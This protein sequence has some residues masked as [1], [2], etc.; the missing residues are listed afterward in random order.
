MSKKSPIRLIDVVNQLPSIK[1][2]A[3]STRTLDNPKIMNVG[4]FKKSDL[5]QFYKFSWV[6]WI[7]PEIDYDAGVDPNGVVQVMPYLL[8]QME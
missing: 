1:R 3:L 6:K 2:I 7:A 4:L 5:Y 8:V